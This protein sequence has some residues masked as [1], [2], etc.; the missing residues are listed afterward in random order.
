MFTQYCNN[1][2]F[3]CGNHLVQVSENETVIVVKPTNEYSWKEH[4]HPSKS[5]QLIQAKFSSR[6]KIILSEIFQSDLTWHRVKAQ[7][8]DVPWGWW[9]T[10]RPHCTNLAWLF[11]PCSTT[12]AQSAVL[13]FSAMSC[14]WLRYQMSSSFLHTAKAASDLPAAGETS[15]L[16]PVQGLAVSPRVLWANWC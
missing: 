12:V 5:C 9:F 7:G 14:F 1:Y 4:C 3:T 10:S 13:I 11:E 2:S 6:G 16:T 8:M 15:A